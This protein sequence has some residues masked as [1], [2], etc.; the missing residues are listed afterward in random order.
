MILEEAQQKFDSFG[1]TFTLEEA[2]QDVHNLIEE[3][4]DYF[5]N[6]TCE[7]C[8]H[9]KEQDG[10]MIFCDAVACED[11]SKIMWHSYTKDF[12]CNKFEP[13]GSE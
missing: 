5:E 10:F 8:I 4:Y 3:I 6:R 13:K 9:N 2:R 1:K 7:N 11:G 12:G